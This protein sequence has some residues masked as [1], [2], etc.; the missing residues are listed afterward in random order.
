MKLIYLT[1]DKVAKVDDWHYSRL[2]AMG[3]WFFV[4]YVSSAYAARKGVNPVSGKRCNVMMHN[5][6]KGEAPEG[7]LWDHVDGDGLNNQEENL[8]LSTS[9]QQ[10]RNRHIAN[11]N[12]SGYKGVSL[13][14]RTG[15]FQAKIAIDR[16]PIHLGSFSTAEEAALAYN[17]A[18]VL[19]FGQFAKLNVVKSENGDSQPPRIVKPTECGD[20][21]Q[22]DSPPVNVARPTGNASKGGGPTRLSAVEK[23]F[24][25]LL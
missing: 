12:T 14:I 1:Q 7:F 25:D 16:K 21:T 5:C 8:R 10:C 20:S 24:I 9:Q 23:A 6:I 18:A 19:Y 22:T 13:H 11:N 17:R 2:M 3:S 4:D 15:K